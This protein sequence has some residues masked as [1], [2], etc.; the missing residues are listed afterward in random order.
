MENHTLPFMSY[1]L[2]FT[3]DGSHVHGEPD[4]N[5]SLDGTRDEAYEWA[6]ETLREIGI[7]QNFG[8]ASHVI[9]TISL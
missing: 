8:A 1:S 9:E 5:H 4:F 7:V 2:I 6:L 3:D